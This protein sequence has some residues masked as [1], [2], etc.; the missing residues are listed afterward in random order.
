MRDVS[1]QQGET[2]CRR[3]RG[4]PSLLMECAPRSFMTRTYEM[5]PPNLRATKKCYG[6]RCIETVE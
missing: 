2:G 1:Q 6:T 5:P 3:R 4:Y